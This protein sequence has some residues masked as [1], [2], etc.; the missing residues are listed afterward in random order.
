SAGRRLR[1]ARDAA[2][3]IGIPTTIP[4]QVSEIAMPATIAIGRAQDTRT[5]M[6]LNASREAP[7][8]KRTT[9]AKVMSLGLVA[10]LLM[11]SNSKKEKR[12]LIMPTTANSTSRR[13]RKPRVGLARSAASLWPGQGFEEPTVGMGAGGGAV[14]LRARHRVPS[15]HHWPSDDHCGG[16]TGGRSIS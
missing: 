1:L 16:A 5:A 2:I 12:P 6:P 14:S 11:P 15:R 9:A 10:P 4:T 13:M 7:H 8:K 3:R